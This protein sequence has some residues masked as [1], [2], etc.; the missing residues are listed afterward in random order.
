MRRLEVVALVLL[1]VGVSSAWG[2]VTI[3]S[4]LGPGDT[5]DTLVHG[6]MGPPWGGISYA[7]PLSFTA[8]GDLILEQVEVAVSLKEG[9]NQINVAIMTDVGNL[10]GAVIESWSLV[11]AMGLFGTN[12]PLVVA[13]S[14][15]QPALSPGT[16]YWLAVSATGATWAYWHQNITGDVGLIA[17]TMSSGPWQTGGGYRGAARVTG[18]PI[19]PA[20]GAISLVLIGLGAL[21]LRRHRRQSAA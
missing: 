6:I 1:S 10:P 18:S 8:S 3:Y 9:D 15:V 13:T 14:V 11:G 5:Y 2:S 4:N 17:Y 19:V 16:Q 21:R 20:P 12:P 7:I